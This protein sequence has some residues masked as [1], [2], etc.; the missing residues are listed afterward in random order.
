LF[1][2]SVGKANAEMLRLRDSRIEGFK[3]LRI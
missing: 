1:I 3:D 2:L